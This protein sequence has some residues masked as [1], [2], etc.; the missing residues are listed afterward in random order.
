MPI[1]WTIASEWKSFDERLLRGA[2]PIQKQEMRRAFYAGAQS[3]L[4]ILMNGL[5]PDAEPTEADLQRMDALDKELQ[6]F[7][8]DVLAGK[9]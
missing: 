7:S 5:D 4:G 2:P 3:F 9:A 6:Q 1:E 8:K